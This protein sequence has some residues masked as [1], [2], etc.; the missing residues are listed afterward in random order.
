MEKTT[1]NTMRDFIPFIFSSFLGSADLKEFTKD[2]GLM[3]INENES[4]LPRNVALKGFFVNI[5]L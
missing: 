2:G 1:S 3:G 4:L 5:G